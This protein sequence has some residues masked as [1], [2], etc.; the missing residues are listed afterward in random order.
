MEMCVFRE[1]NQNPDPW[2]QKLDQF[3]TQLNLVG[4]TAAATT[5]GTTALTASYARNGI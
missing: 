5:A 1:T 2:M 3:N 4:M